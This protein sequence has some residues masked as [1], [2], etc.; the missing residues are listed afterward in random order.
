MA[1]KTKAKT[2]TKKTTTADKTK[3]KKTTKT[4]GKVAVTPVKVTK[5]RI[6]VVFDRSGSMDNIRKGAVSV[7]NNVVETI[8]RNSRT[9]DQ[10]TEVSF[11]Y[12]D[13]GVSPV[14]V[15]QEAKSLKPLTVDEYRPQGGT[16]LFD[17]VALAIDTMEK[18]DAEDTAYAVMVLTDGEENASTRYPT[19]EPKKFKELLRSK[20]KTDL[21]TFAFMVP[22][23]EMQTFLNLTGLP[24]GNVMPWSDIKTADEAGSAG[25]EKFYEDRRA[26]KTSSKEVFIKVRPDLSNL[27]KRDLKKM[28]DITSKCRIWAV[29]DKEGLV[30]FVKRHNNGK[31]TKG[32][33]LYQLVETE[34]VQDYKI[35]ALISKNDPNKVLIGGRAE[36]GLPEHGTAKVTP[37]DHGDFDIFY[38]STSF[39]R[40]LDPNT[41]LVYINDDEE[42]PEA[43]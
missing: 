38:Q 2:S 32:H 12:F 23:D 29:K 8:K 10:E 22:A 4:A 41:R 40:Q 31:F 42:L 24:D 11:F 43:K 9:G 3:Q 18:K 21:W 15:N 16:A 36:V 39:T 5:N 30:D 25:V 20:I 35:M 26:G 28:E 13:N 34:K 19:K 7:Y 33:A 14:L 1:N 17:A 27:K 37:G 6:A